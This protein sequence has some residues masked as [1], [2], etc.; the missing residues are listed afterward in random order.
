M[1]ESRSDLMFATLGQLKVGGGVFACTF[2]RL[3]GGAFLGTLGGAALLMLINLMLKFSSLN[4]LSSRSS[5]C[6]C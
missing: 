2:G 1:L 3:G 6:C 4:N 5:M